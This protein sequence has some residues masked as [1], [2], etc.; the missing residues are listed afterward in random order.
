M[1]AVIELLGEN[2]D[3]GG[4]LF[5]DDD[6]AILIGNDDVVGV[7]SDTVAIDGYVG[8]AEAV[9]PHG[10][11]RHRAQGVDRKADSFELRE[12]AYAIACD[13]QPVQVPGW[14]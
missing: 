7:D 10:G 11:R 4:F 1:L 2:Q 6:N 9:V 14:M 3:F 13:I 8:A 12:I 5:R